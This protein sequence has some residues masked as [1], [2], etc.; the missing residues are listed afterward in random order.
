VVAF[1]YVHVA[2]YQSKSTCVPAALTKPRS[3]P[4]DHCAMIIHNLF[5]LHV[6]SLL[7]SLLFFLRALLDDR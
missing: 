5:P 6:L 3:A 2:V 4:H 7:L 1:L